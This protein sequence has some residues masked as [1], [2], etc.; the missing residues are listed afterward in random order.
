MGIEASA[1]NSFKIGSLVFKVL[2]GEQ[3]PRGSAS[4]ELGFLRLPV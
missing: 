2:Q 3:G 4:G 1:L